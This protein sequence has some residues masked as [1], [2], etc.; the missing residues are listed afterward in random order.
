MEFLN[1]AAGGIPVCKCYQ[2]VKV[3]TQASNITKCFK[4]QSVKLQINILCY[5]FIL[6]HSD[7]A[8]TGKCVLMSIKHLKISNRRNLNPL[9]SIHEINFNQPLCE[10]LVG[11]CGYQRQQSGGQW[12][13]VSE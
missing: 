12:R 9:F 4:R 1:A 8:E 3:Q 6:L 7:H 13:N 10:L 2:P 11:L 5:V